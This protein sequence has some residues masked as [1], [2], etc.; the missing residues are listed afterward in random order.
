V[1]RID[2]PYGSVLLTGDIEAGQEAELLARHAGDLAADLL[3]PPHHGSRGASTAEFI[4]AVQPG[5]T[6]F[7]AGY[8]NRFGHPAPEVVARYEAAG[9]RIWRTDRDGAVTLHLGAAG[10]MAASE[11]GAVRRYWHGR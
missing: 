9:T 1:L 2:G 6:V 10:P 7:S 3:V 4:A 11:A 8:R 5:Q